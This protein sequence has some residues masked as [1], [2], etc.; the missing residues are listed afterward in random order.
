MVVETQHNQILVVLTGEIQNGRRRLSSHH[1]IAD[2]QPRLASGESIEP[3]AVSLHPRL[4]IGVIRR[5]DVQDIDGCTP[6][7][8]HG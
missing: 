8:C 5:G 2:G 4:V 1:V 3:A 6:R 7:F